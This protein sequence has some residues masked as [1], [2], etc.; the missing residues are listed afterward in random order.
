MLPEWYKE[1]QSYLNNEKKPSDI[2]TSTGTIKKCVPVFDSLT[3]GYIIR[4]PA[5][6]FIEQKDGLPYYS[7][8]SFQIIDFH[9]ISQAE[10]HPE[11]NSFPYPKIINPWIFKTPKGYST[12]FIPP[13]H[14][15]NVI[16]ILPGLV[17]TDKYSLPVNFPFVLKDVNFTGLIPAG[18][19]IAQAIPIKRDSFKIKEGS[20]DM[21]KNCVKERGIMRARFFD[22]YRNNYWFRKQYK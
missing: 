10:L 13:I 5:D 16:N 12:L 9:P 22:F 2:H 1:T 14:H 7:W 18:T 21:A 17:D 15:N 19:P 8:P 3:V 11:Q 6:L 4:L 20:S